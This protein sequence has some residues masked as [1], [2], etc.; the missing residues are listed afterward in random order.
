MSSNMVP[1]Q[2]RID[3]DVKREANALFKDLG[4]DMSTA[5]NMFLKQCIICDGLPM[6]V[7]RQRYSDEVLAAMK[8][9]K[10]PEKLESFESFDEYKKAMEDFV[11]EEG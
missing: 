5:V 9:A 2:I 3:A 4:L 10:H 11:N 8:E 1:T 6:K 7:D